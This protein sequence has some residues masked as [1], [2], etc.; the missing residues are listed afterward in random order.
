[1]QDSAIYY[2]NKALDAAVKYGDAS[3][4]ANLS[5]NLG[6]FHFNLKHYPEAEKFIDQALQYVQQTNDT[7][8]TFNI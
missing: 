4:L 3:W 5:L 6:V 7:L 1:M 8:T 2:Y